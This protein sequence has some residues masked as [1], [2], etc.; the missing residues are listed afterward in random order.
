MNS[1][2]DLIRCCKQIRTMM[3]STQTGLLST[4]FVFGIISPHPDAFY[5]PNVK[6]TSPHWNFTCPQWLLPAFGRWAGVNVMD[7]SCNKA[8]WLPAQN[9]L[10]GEDTDNLNYCKVPV[11]SM[12]SNMYWRVK[13]P[14]MTMT[15]MGIVLP[16]EGWM[17]EQRM[18]CTH[19]A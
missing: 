9:C 16:E 15:H 2:C 10:I 18:I 3:W 11:T 1:R 5:K 7:W 14:K 4:E 8:T 6:I 17:S 13:I 19:R 12:N